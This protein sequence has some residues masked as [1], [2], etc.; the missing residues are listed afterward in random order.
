M[1]QPGP[2]HP[3]AVRLLGALALAASLATPAFA[4][5]PAPA[6][7]T[8]ATGAANAADPVVARVN[9]AEIRLSDLAEAAQSLLGTGA[10]CTASQAPAR[11]RL[12][13][14]VES[15]FPGTARRPRLRR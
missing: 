10:G 11:P 9:K 12:H 6:A 1:P 4:Q 13:S 15:D 2:L 8:S 14:S 5:A 7:P 3:V